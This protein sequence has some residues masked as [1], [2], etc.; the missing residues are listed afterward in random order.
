MGSKLRD[1]SV[2]QFVFFLLYPRPKLPS[3]ES[4]KWSLWNPPTMAYIELESHYC[5]GFTALVPTQKLP[6]W[7]VLLCTPMVAFQQRNSRFFGD[8]S[9][10]LSVCHAGKFFHLFPGS[11][12]IPSGEVAAR[13]PLLQVLKIIH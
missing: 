3:L 4:S 12:G 2:V 11:G 10:L 1:S 7:L 8:R 5:N 6:L 13:P 9:V